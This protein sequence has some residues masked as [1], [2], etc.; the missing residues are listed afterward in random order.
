MKKSQEVVE[1]KGFRLPTLSKHK[2]F[3]VH[4]ILR[5]RAGL[6]REQVRYSSEFLW[7]VAVSRDCAWDSVVAID[8]ERED[9]FRE[10]QVHSHTDWNDTWKQQDV[11]EQVQV[12]CMREAFQSDKDRRN[13]NHKYE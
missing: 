2:S 4:L 7:D 12:E 6:V 11:F 8:F 3:E 13:D 5:K 10:V 9:R 1:C